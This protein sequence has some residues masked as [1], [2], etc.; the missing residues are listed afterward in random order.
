MFRQIVLNLFFLNGIL[1][2]IVSNIYAQGE[3]QGDIIGLTRMI[4]SIREVERF[5][6]VC[7]RIKGLFGFTQERRFL[8]GFVTNFNFTP[9]D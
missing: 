7:N 3:E 5:F 6:Y 4:A 1:V 2:G 9:P 8:H